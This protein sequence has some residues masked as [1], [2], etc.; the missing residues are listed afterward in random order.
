[1]CVRLCVCDVFVRVCTCGFMRLC[2][3]E[4]IVCGVWCMCSFRLVY[5]IVG[6]STGVYSVL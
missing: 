3:C 1:M 2:M 5:I 4:S 6:V